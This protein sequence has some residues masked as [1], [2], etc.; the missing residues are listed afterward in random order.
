MRFADMVDNDQQLPI[1]F[2]LVFNSSTNLFNVYI[3][4]KKSQN[5]KAYCVRHILK[6]LLLRQ[7]RGFLAT[8]W[9]IL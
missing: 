9:A 8:W 3:S 4:P 7:Q 2:A 5:Y 1:P 6:I